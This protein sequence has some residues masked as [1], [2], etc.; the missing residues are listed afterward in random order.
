M[1]SKMVANV[2]IFFLN[3]IISP[4]QSTFVPR[5]FIMD[6]VLVAYEI[7][8]GIHTRVQVNQHFMALKLDVSKAYDMI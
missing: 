6:N 5:Q 7:N 2:M 1:G 8:H 3:E 4:T